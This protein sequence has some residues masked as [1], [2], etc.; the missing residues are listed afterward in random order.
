MFLLAEGTRCAPSS[1]QE[2]SSFPRPPSEKTSPRICT[3]CLK[4]TATSLFPYGPLPAWRASRSSPLTWTSSWTCCDVSHEDLAACKA[5]SLHQPVKLKPLL[6]PFQPH[7]WYKW[8]RRGRK[9]VPITS[10]ASSFSEKSP[11]RR[12]SR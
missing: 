7:R 11:K 8:T 5:V 9:F 3:S 2:A 12:P 4:W 6:S 10:G 1:N